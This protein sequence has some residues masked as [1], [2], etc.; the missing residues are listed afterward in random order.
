MLDRI[1]RALDC[2]LPLLAGDETHTAALRLFNGYTEGLPGFAVDVYASAL[3]LHN[4]ANLPASLDTLIPQVVAMARERLPWLTAGLLKTRRATDMEKRR[5]ELLFGTQLPNKVREN[6]TWYA[7]NLRLNQD[8]GLYLD[9]RGLRGWL[10]QNCA[11]LRIL[12]TFAYTG[13]LGAACMAGG[14]VRAVQLD[15][16]REFLNLGK[17]TCSM[18]GF[19]IRKDDFITANFFVRAAQMRRAGELFDLALLDPPIFSTT[20]AGNVD[21]LGENERLIN[22]IRPLVSDGGRLVA[23]NNAVFLSGR[24]YLD[25][26]ESLCA[27]GFLAIEELIPV[28]EDFSGYPETQSGFP[29]ADPAP[30]NHSTK[31]AVLRVKRK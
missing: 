17:D 14:A 25:G 19:P 23:I 18:N 9:T 10:K 16:N 5:G 1:T 29:P 31:I 20:N 21:L 27:S 11:G 12:N 26:L 24:D 3:V 6:G 13:S 28:L 8:A 15:L 22:K 30:F 7:V 4:Q 2:R